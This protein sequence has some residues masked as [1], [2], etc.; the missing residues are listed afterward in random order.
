[1]RLRANGRL[2]SEMRLL[3]NSFDLTFALSVPSSDYAVVPDLGYG[4]VL[5]GVHHL[6]HFAL[7]LLTVGKIDEVV[8]SAYINDLEW[9]HALS[10]VL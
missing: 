2:P 1:M 3:P 9:Y 5:D 4:E 7:D 8:D 6:M 10:H